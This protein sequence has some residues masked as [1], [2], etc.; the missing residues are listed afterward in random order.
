MLFGINANSFKYEYAKFRM[1]GRKITEF[2]FSHA[3][4]QQCIFFAP[5]LAKF[6]NFKLLDQD[7]L[8][9]FQK[10]LHTTIIEREK[11]KH[12][13]NDLVDVILDMKSKS[14]DNFNFG[15]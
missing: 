10:S 6:F 11:S 4:Q 14:D 5:G 1:A 2:S 7:I 8:D 13:R 12:R 15:K 9:F 3:V